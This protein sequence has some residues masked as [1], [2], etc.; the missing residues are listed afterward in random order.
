ME[1]SK[2]TKV[3]KHCQTE[4]SK[5]A[6][7]CP[8]C[9]K[10]QGGIGKWIVIAIVVFLIIGAAGGGSDDE[11]VKNSGKLENNNE[12]EN[13]ETEKV[14]YI[15]ATKDK[16]NILISNNSESEYFVLFEMKD[17]YNDSYFSK[18]EN[19]LKPKH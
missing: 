14:E 18:L 12:N 13:K 11:P 17:I 15:K 2:E 19:M 7:I 8:Q 6:K 3:C 9:H 10:K 1:N 5:K 16:T 4:I